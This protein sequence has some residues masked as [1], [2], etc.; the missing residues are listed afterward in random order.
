MQV[1]FIIMLTQIFRIHS[2]AGE[3]DPERVG[4][5]IQYGNASVRRISQQGQKEGGSG[6]DKCSC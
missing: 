6:K 3:L 2:G 4:S 5:G 1:S